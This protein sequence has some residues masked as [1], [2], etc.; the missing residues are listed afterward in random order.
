MV[1]FSR[2]L[3]NELVTAK[4]LRDRAYYRANADKIRAKAKEYRA[5]HKE[6][7]NELNKKYEKEK[8]DRDPDAARAKVR[9]GIAKRKQERPWINYQRAAREKGREYSLTKEDAQ[10]IMLRPC[11]Y[12][13]YEGSPYVGMDRKNNLIGYTI[14][15][16]AACCSGCNYAKRAMSYEEFWTYLHRVAAYINKITFT[17]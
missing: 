13:G 16:V 1:H 4:Q 12:C 8:F 10:S 11:H 14:D 7:H 9:R 17:Y 2:Y 15:N 5:K 3:K 6:R